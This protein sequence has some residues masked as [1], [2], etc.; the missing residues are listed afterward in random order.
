MRTQV[1]TTQFTN[2]Y[3]GTF[4]AEVGD[5]PRTVMKLVT[6]LPDRRVLG[7]HMIG[8]YVS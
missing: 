5:K 2:L 1:Y 7:V 4:V 6:L 3:Y 8:N